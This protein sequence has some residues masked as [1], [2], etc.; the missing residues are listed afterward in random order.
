MFIY[1]TERA[2]VGGA[3]EGEGGAGSPLRRELNAGLDP[4]TPGS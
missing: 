1:L 2:Q 4:R 3:T